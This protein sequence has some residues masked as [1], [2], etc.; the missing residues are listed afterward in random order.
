MGT[1]MNESVQFLTSHHGNLPKMNQFNSSPNIMGTNG[2][3]SVQILTKHHW[4]LHK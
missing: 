3:E 1:F 4:N 2:N